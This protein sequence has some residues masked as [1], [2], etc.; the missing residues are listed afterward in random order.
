MVTGTLTFDVGPDRLEADVNLS[1]NA[2]RA[3][4]ARRAAIRAPFQAFDVRSGKIVQDNL[5]V[6]PLAPGY[7]A[8][9]GM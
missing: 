4:D 9:K 3:S 5:T 8:L 2:D 6:K 7:A 1:V